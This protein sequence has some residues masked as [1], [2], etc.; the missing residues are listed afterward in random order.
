MFN[1]LLVDDDKI[2]AKVHKIYF[3]DCGFNILTVENGINALKVIEQ[4]SIDCIILDISLPDING[5]DLCKRIKAIVDVPIIFLSNY[6]EEEKRI[7][8]FLSGGDDY[9]VKPHSIRELELRIRA[10]IENPREKNMKRHVRCFGDLRIDAMIRKVS[11]GEKSIILT[12]AEF[13]VLWFLTEHANEVFSA[14]EIY[15]N[16][17][18]MPDLGDAHTVQV[19]I[20]K[21]RKKLNSLSGEHLFIQTIWGKGYAFNYL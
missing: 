6:G 15:E 13:D 11:F 18:K 12:A 3:E 14:E 20:A 1:I 16:V 17:W 8:G 2:L 7:S 21:M 4:K 10:K 5:F 19:H 9:L